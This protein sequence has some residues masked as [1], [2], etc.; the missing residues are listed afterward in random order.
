[1]GCCSLLIYGGFS[2]SFCFLAFIY[3]FC[4]FVNERFFLCCCDAILN[5]EFSAQ[6]KECIKEQTA[7]AF[8][9]QIL[10]LQIFSIAFLKL[11]PLVHGFLHC[12]P[13]RLQSKLVLHP[14][15]S[16]LPFSLVSAQVMHPGRSGKRSH[17]SAVLDIRG[18]YHFVRKRIIEIS[19][20]TMLV[21]YHC[22]EGINFSE[23]Y[24][25]AAIESFSNFRH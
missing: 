14:S 8:C 22:Y 15:R 17:I 6:L 20:I 1:M 5:I 23:I 21:F 2:I 12:F 3:G 4:Y 9:V 25:R 13:M 11:K 10:L 18:K 7:I 19:I 24:L 16:L